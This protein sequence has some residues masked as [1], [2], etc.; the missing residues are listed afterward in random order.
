[1]ASYQSRGSFHSTEQL[2]F[3]GSGR[4]RELLNI[5]DPPWSPN[6]SSTEIDS[7]ANAPNRTQQPVQAAAGAA[8][9]GQEVD[10]SFCIVSNIL[11]ARLTRWQLIMEDL[12]P[13]DR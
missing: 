3:R 13:L 9:N 5:H 8:Y 4:Y 7:V 6:A 1:M 12:P 2:S 11:V 10:V